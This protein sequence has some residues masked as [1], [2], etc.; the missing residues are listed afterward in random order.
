MIATFISR[1]AETFDVLRLRLSDLSGV[2]TAGV[3]VVSIAT[4]LG[5]ADYLFARLAPMVTSL[6]TRN[7]DRGLRVRVAALTTAAACVALI[8]VTWVTV[9]VLDPS[10][11]GQSGSDTSFPVRLRAEF[12]L[13]SEPRDLVFTGVDRGYISFEDSISAF[14]ITGAEDELDLVLT[15]MAG[16]DVIVNPRGLAFI[17]GFL[18]ASEQGEP[19]ADAPTGL[20]STGGQVVRF[21][22]TA[23]GELTEKTNLI[24]DV[25]IANS[26]HGINGMAIGPDGFVYL[27][28]GG[29]RDPIDPLPQNF[30]WLGSIL[31]FRPD[32]TDLEV[33]ANGLRNVYDLEFDT[34]G[35][36]WGVDN[37]GPTYRGYRA[38]EILQIKQ[39]ANYGYPFEGTFDNHQVR[40]D[41]PVWA[42]QGHDLEGSAG[43]ELT[44]TLGL[45]TG[46]LIGARTLTH[47][48]YAE[49]DSGLF[50]HGEFD[51]QGHEAVFVRQGYFTIV[52]ASENRLLYVGVTGLSLQSNLYILEVTS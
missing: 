1:P 44:E 52:E 30:E 41:G 48:R 24:T 6:L 21:T 13:P 14:E 45:P 28:V 34:K 37:D 27:S 16:P 46:L 50:A 40:T 49:D 42:F 36:L 26:L 18:F 39:G 17:D 35:R 47:F 15:E 19:M 38:E 10:V 9:N 7:A 51:F 4:G 31:R 20:Y 29:T 3:F 22:V 5:I 32:G 12:D 8:A 33:F 43:I 23:Q 2:A 25:P 11:Q